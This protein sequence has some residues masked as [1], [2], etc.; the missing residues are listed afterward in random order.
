MHLP[1]GKTAA[2]SLCFDG[3]FPEHL[4][5]AA[6]L[7][8]VSGVRASFFV[9]A[10]SIMENIAGWRQLATAG[11]EIANHSLFGT[12][13]NGELPGWTLALIEE[14]LLETSR[15][16][17]DATDSLA[18]S[19]A[20][21]GE[22][23]LCK[24]GDYTP[25]VERHFAAA[26]LS[27]GGLNEL[28]AVNPLRV[29]CLPWREFQCAAGEGIPAPGMWSVL[30]FERFFSPECAAAESDLESVLAAIGER[31]EIWVAPFGEVAS[32]MESS[33]SR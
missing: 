1:I 32:A 24:E 28:S 7:L 25:V 9:T 29:K 26:R 21:D 6:A 22:N 14:D 12:T 20:Y 5:L 17:L 4:E 19:F 18:R 3:G 23:R 30:A 10:P 27:G 16:I 2:L 31:S 11:H 13:S 33:D 8:A 15:A